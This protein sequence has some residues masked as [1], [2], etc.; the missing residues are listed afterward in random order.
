M[1]LVEKKVGKRAQIQSLDGIGK[2]RPTFPVNILDVIQR[3][4]HQVV[5]RTQ[6]L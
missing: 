4:K 3:A 2:K 6:I 5:Q 1:F